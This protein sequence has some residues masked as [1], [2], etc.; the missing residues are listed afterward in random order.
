MTI[1]SEFNQTKVIRNFS[2]WAKNKGN[3][4]AVTLPFSL[5]CACYLPFR[6][7][8]I[9][10]NNCLEHSA[11]FRR[12]VRVTL[13]EKCLN[14]ELFLV[15]IFLYSDWIQENT[16]LNTGKYG[17]EI[18]P[19]L[20]TFHAVWYLIKHDLLCHFYQFY[21]DFKSLTQN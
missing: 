2:I 12:M 17:P 9:N 13:C 18:T 11:F 4:S 14:T 1:Y 8:T 21:R 16:D 20:D 5:I 3:K 10:L 6:F 19:Y 15:R 7:R